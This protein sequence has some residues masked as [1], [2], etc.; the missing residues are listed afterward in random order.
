MT[1]YFTS[2]LHFNHARIC[3]YTGRPFSNVDDMNA[4]LI[5]NWNNTVK[6]EDEVFMLGDFCMG[7]GGA[8]PALSFARALHGTKYMIAGNH[9]ES[10]RNAYE[11][12]G[13]PFAWVK[14]YAEIKI[15]GQRIILMHF[16]IETWHKKAHGALHFHGHSHGTTH[17][18]RLIRGRVDVGVD[19]WDLFPVTMQ[20][21]RARAHSY[22]DVIEDH[23]G[24]RE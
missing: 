19:C 16:P 24:A 20:K 7:S 21:A 15:D 10:R 18:S 12:E 23:H 11:A 4:A 9:D 13:S 8:P 3:E 1:A 22:K 6:P 2:D 5:H 14:D 17:P